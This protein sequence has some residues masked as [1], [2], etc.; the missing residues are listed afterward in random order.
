MGSSQSTDQTVSGI[1]GGKA[2]PIPKGM[3]LSYWLQNVRASPLLDHRTTEE[4]PKSAEIVII[5]S[6]VCSCTISPESNTEQQ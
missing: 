1:E 2:F 4:L 5:G 3:S 6:G